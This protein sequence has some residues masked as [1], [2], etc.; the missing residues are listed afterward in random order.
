MKKSAS[1]LIAM[2]V[3]ALIFVLGMVKDIFDGKAL[4]ETVDELVEQKLKEKLE[5]KGS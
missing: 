2:G 5:E 3:G 4:E 1:S